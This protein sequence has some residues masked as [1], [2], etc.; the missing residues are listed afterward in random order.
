MPKDFEESLFG[1]AGEVTFD[2]SV[3]ARFPEAKLIPLFAVL[4]S[5]RF[6]F[7]REAAAEADPIESF[8][9]FI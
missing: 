7:R 6:C 1:D 3:W 4:L 8:L 5:C 2:A 9:C